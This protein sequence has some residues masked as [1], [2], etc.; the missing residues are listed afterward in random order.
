M[1]GSETKS[2]PTFMFGSETWTIGKE[3]SV[4]RLESQQINFM[5]HLWV[6]QG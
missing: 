6:P 5:R 4:E 1:F 2:K 3:D